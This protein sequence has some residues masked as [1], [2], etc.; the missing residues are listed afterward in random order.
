LAQQQ[1]ILDEVEKL[2][3]RRNTLPSFGVI[4]SQHLIA[5]FMTLK[6]LVDTGLPIFD[7]IK[8]A[9]NVTDHLRLKNALLL[10][11]DALTLGYTLADA[12]RQQKKIFSDHQIGLIEA[13]EETGDLSGALG[14]II[15]YL[16]W[17]DSLG[18]RMARTLRYPLIVFM[19]LALLSWVVATSIVPQIL[20]YFGYNDLPMPLSTSSLIGFAAILQQYGFIAVVGFMLGFVVLKILLQI[21]PILN[22]GVSA[23]LFHLPFIGD[24]VAEHDL[25]RFSRV[26]SALLASGLSVRRSMMIGAKAM[27]NR[28]IQKTLEQANQTIEK[29]FSITSALSRSSMFPR[30]AVELIALGEQGG[31]LEQTF[32]LIAEDSDKRLRMMVDR[33]ISY[34]EPSLMALIAALIIWIALA[35]TAPLYQSLSLMG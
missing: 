32:K 4:S 2:K 12:M 8:K 18:E 20:I 34:L 3:P 31:R 9:E 16:S 15:T 11:E 14:D 21:V 10:I 7:V 19:M 6:T 5:L 23:L 1:L 28:Y 33:I 35:I 30:Y 22:Y 13:A 29:G 27:R 25:A 26:F 24:L 17:S